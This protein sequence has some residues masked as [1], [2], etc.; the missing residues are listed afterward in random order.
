MD[1]VILAAG[2]GE[3]LRPL[4]D[5]TPKPLLHYMGK[6][7][8]EYLISDLVQHGLKKIYLIVGHLK[9]Q[10][11]SF[12]RVMESRY[13][14]KIILISQSPLL[15]VAHALTFLPDALSDPF[16]LFV[17]DSLFSDFPYQ[18]F[19]R[20]KKPMFLVQESSSALRKTVVTVKNDQVVD[21]FYNYDQSFSQPVLIEIGAL[22][23]PHS[24]LAFVR[25]QSYQ[26]EVPL[27]T[28]LQKMVHTGTMFGIVRYTR[29]VK[30]ISS[31]KDLE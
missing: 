28:I 26:A 11:P 6:P 10:F 8:L 20:S 14:V 27:S 2:E 31:V 15:G 1:I 22:S 17:A 19:L 13:S 23:L 7:I 12:V 24:V 18:D 16:L 21:C 5:K 30:S 25:E 4:T 29:T 3:R 9:E